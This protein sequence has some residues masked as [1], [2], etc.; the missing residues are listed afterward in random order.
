M[1]DNQYITKDG[2]RH[3]EIGFNKVPIRLGI[4]P[5]SIARTVKSGI[6]AKKSKYDDH[7]KINELYREWSRSPK[8]PSG[9]L[10]EKVLLRF[11]DFYKPRI[12]AI[13]KKYRA[14][15]PVF[16]DDDLQQ[17]ALLGIFQAL[18]KYDHAP[19]V[20]MR[21]ST[22]L[23]WS[24]RNIFQRAIG[25]SDK[26]VEVYDGNDR[27][28]YSISYQDFL[29]RKKAIQSAGH[30]YVV[31][32]RL[33]YL[34]DIINPGGPTACAASQG[35]APPLYSGNH[36]NAEEDT[37]GPDEHGGPLPGTRMIH[38]RRRP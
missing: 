34:A 37:N 14:L 3:P 15:S 16:D 35:D 22:Y 21:F 36:S 20:E 8:A 4:S 32:S 25:Y 9:N 38:I 27:L 23:E 31:R 26:F 11:Y 12:M 33:C 5:V 10:S 1:S 29:S 24:I 6:P 7:E 17:T 13:V 19:H 30:T 28:L 18:A 2:H